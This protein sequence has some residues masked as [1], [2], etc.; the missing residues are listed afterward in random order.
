M[1]GDDCR[2]L[3]A[4]DHVSFGVTEAKRGL[5]AIRIRLFW[6]TLMNH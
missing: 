2:V 1:E 6:G 3:Q 4:G 5:K